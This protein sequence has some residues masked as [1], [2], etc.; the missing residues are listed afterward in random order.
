MDINE[1]MSVLPH[2]YPF[3]LMDR[4]LEISDDMIRA[5]KN[6]TVNE[7]FFI[8][9]FPGWPVMPGVLLVEGMAQAGAYLV[10]RG[11]ED[12]TNKLMYFSGIDNCRFRRPV[13]PGDQVIYEVKV[14][15][16]R[17]RFA[18]LD[19]KALV[20]GE[21]ACEAELKSVMVERQ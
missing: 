21:I 2:R 4:V 3:L 7:P 1:I 10:F 19:G 8:G 12:R 15:Y 13:I 20:D 11:V 17:R 18:K 5:L 6:V 9:H 16:H 14:L